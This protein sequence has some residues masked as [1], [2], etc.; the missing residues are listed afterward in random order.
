MA[1]GWPRLWPWLL[2]L[3]CVLVAVA[4]EA[5]WTGGSVGGGDFSSGGSSSGGSSDSDSSYGGGSGGD[6]FA[7]IEF[8]VWLFRVNPLLG[9]AALFAL[10]LYGIWSAN[11][12]AGA[13]GHQDSGSVGSSV[14]SATSR[15]WFEVDLTEVRIAL[16]GRARSYLQ[17]ELMEQGRRAD[18]RTKAGL[19]AL[20][21]V[22]VR[23]LKQ[24]SSAWIYAGAKNFRP[25]SSIL[26]E[27]TF[28][29]LAGEARAKF[30]HEL[31]RKDASGLREGEGHGVVRSAEREGEGVVLVTLI[32][33]ASREIKDFEATSV[34]ELV[35]VLDDL[36]ALTD[37]S[38]V[39][40]EISWLPAEESDR[41]STA[42][43]EALHPDMKKLPGATG[44]RLFCTYCKGPFAAELPKC[45]HCGAPREP[46]S[47][48]ATPPPG[49][50]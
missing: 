34:A 38:L 28:K 22:V 35:N 10:L 42:T 37:Q 29:R 26:A 9:F 30:T 50:A 49:S 24:S 16:D 4:G 7:A 25:M 5:Q 33:A 31:L 23:A 46:A 36:A 19:V 45:P 17:R 13:A 6:V 48:S 15:R 44:G 1:R 41:M 12:Q 43:L 2:V 39:A 21:R 8:F 11:R 47:S 32:V 14:P 18:T 40:V 20:L 3:A 27:A